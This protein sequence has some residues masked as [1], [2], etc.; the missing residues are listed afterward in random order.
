L[1]SSC[2]FL[3][4]IAAVLQIIISFNLQNQRGGGGWGGGWIDSRNSNTQFCLNAFPYNDCITRFGKQLSMLRDS[5][6]T[7]P[8]LRSAYYTVIRNFKL[9]LRVRSM[10]ISHLGFS[11]ICHSS[12]SNFEP[13]VGNTQTAIFS[14][15]QDHLNSWNFVRSRKLQKKTCSCPR[16]KLPLL[17]CRVKTTV[18]NP[19]LE[20][21]KPQH[22][23]RAGAQIFVDKKIL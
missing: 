20:P 3:I 6:M 15:A 8:D 21:V 9:R 4:D 23:A 12:H 1:Q 17:N 5:L 2:K 18:A 10:F 22:F 13:G 19:E 14:F 11:R 7:R 16:R